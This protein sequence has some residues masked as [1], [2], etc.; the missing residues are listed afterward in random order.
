MYVKPSFS[1]AS[2]VPPLRIL[3]ISSPKNRSQ[4]YNQPYV[5]ICDDSAFL[6]GKN[7]HQDEHNFFK[8]AAESACLDLTNIIWYVN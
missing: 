4:L 7:L 3:T 8:E 5:S 1:T 2:V 6:F